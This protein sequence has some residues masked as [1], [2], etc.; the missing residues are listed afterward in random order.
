MP[1]YPLSTLAATIS[2]TGI[3][4]PTYD[5]ILTSLQ[6]SFQSIYG[7]DAYISA[8]SQDGQM[9]AVFARAISDS[10]DMA[11]AV[12][13]AFSP[14]YGQGAG[15]SSTV[16]INGLVRN[17]ATYS[18]A[19]GMVVGTVGT[20]ITNGS[21]K[22]VNGN[23]W[24]L[25]ASV[26]IPPAGQ[27]AVTVTAQNPGAVVATAGTINVINSPIYGWQ[28][29]VSTSDALQGAPV[30]TDAQLRARQA[31]STSLP[32]LTVMGALVGA[33]KDLTGV[34]QVQAYEN[35]TGSIDAN[36]LP[37]YSIAL[38]VLGGN[39]Q[40]IANT[41][42][43]KKTPGT[44]T[45]GT[46]TQTVVDALSGISTVI[47]FFRPTVFT[48]GVLV[49]LKA[50]ANYSSV[51]GAGIQEAVAAYLDSLEIGA[52][53]YA[54]RLIAAANTVQNNDTFNITSVYT[55]RDDMQIT[56]GPFSAG[57]TSVYITSTNNVP[58]GSKIG[59]T[60]DNSTIHYATVSGVSGIQLT[61]SPAI[62][63][64]RS[65]NNGA[66][67]YVQGDLVFTFNQLATA[68]A[69]NVIVTAS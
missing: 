46:T 14:T 27:I 66:A 12:Y 47:R 6:T 7:S 69:A 57:A 10:N 22:D 44:P 11:I 32:A 50:L 37:P 63:G 51:V 48:V 30:E 18:T 24:N 4:A 36:T 67:V 15:L 54:T 49:N 42:G 59:I 65:A 56:G 53:V 64:G 61:F 26:T 34:Q 5:E 68:A 1:T 33:V 25:P 45:Y 39:S 40:Q 55:T 19:D 41:I 17:V 35:P 23:V 31:V 13:S 2:A 9:L 8:D 20:V 43:A 16:K 62:P 52:D 21:V 60:L 3:S 28:S 29:F 58:N 38:V